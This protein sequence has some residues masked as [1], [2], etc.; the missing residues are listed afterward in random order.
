MAKSNPFILAL[1]LIA[2]LTLSACGG[3]GGDGGGNQTPPPP[4]T[5][6]TIS[7]SVSAP[8]STVAQY[9]RQNVLSMIA[10]LL[11]SDL[12]AA[13]TGLTPVTNATVELIRIDKSGAQVGDV[14]ASTTTDSVTGAYSLDYEGTLS[15][16]LVVQVTGA[17]GPMR[18]LAVA[19]TTDIN[20]VTEYV[21]QQILASIINNNNISLDAI[22]PKTV[23]ELIDFVESLDITFSGSETVAESAAAIDSVADA[24][25]IDS[26]ISNSLNGSLIGAWGLNQ[27]GNTT[28]EVVIV[29]LEDSSFMLLHDGVADVDGMPGIESGTYQFDA[30]SGALTFNETVDTNGSWGISDADPDNASINNNTLTLTFVNSAFSFTRIASD[31]SPL[32]GA[33]TADASVSDG[34]LAVI[35]F[36]DDGTFTQG[37]GGTNDTCG[38]ATAGMDRGTYIWDSSADTVAFTTTTDTNGC[39]GVNNST[40][41]ISVFGDNLVLGDAVDGDFQ[42]RRITSAPRSPANQ[43]FE[44]DLTTKTATSTMTYSACPGV[45]GGWSYSFTETAVT[46]TGSDT[47]NNCVL[48]AEESFDWPVLEFTSDFVFNCQAYPVCTSDDFN[49]TLSGVDG[50]NRNFQVTT[51]FDNDNNTITF[52]KNVQGSGTFT[53]VITLQ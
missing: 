11:I 4:P 39:I 33:W 41:N 9:E 40:A 10:S 14:I 36:H 42:L 13:I 30:A 15:S 26:E 47:W 7:G 28:T 51:S 17:S 1:A 5:L 18:A 38:D 35:V 22:T 24:N 21:T 50:D 46:M 32:V 12:Q 31:S 45:P 43:V 16:D 52:T 29:F 20:P 37:Q 19:E 27:D 53:E 8:S 44:V 23:A 2:S 49:K 3:G 6:T 34:N 48:G 25:G